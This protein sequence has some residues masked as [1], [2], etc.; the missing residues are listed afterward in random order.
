[1]SNKI[2]QTLEAYAE[3]CVKAGHFKD[4]ESAIQRALELLRLDTGAPSADAR[5]QGGQWKGQ[6]SVAPDFDDL[7]DDISESFGIQ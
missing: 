1:M 3:T 5:R 6:V 7:P 4:A 2:V